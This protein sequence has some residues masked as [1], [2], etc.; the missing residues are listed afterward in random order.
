MAFIDE[1]LG[2]DENILYAARQHVVLLVSRIFTKLILIGIL[3]ATAIVSAQAFANNTT[4]I[5]AGFTASQLIPALAYFISVLLFLSIFSDFLR[6]NAEQF[7]ITDRRLIQIFG[8]LNKTV[9][10]SPLEKISDARLTQSLFG[11]MFG[12]GTLNIYTTAEDGYNLEHIVAPMDFKR[13]L[14]EARYNYERGFGY[15]DTPQQSHSAGYGNVP[16]HQY[17]QSEAQR[18]IQELA[19]LRDRG[20]LSMDEFEAKKREILNKI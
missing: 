15:L 17:S 10:D 1:L 16:S 14:M 18:K 8:A 9:I 7:L 20:I 19:T 12:Y 11:R 2:R 6:W 3:V 4:T 13:A 5:I